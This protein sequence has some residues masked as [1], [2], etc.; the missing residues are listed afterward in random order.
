MSGVAFTRAST[1]GPILDFLEEG[2][3]CVEHVFHQADLPVQICSKPDALI[4]WRD[5]CKVIE[6]GSREIGDDALPARLAMAAGVAGLG[7]YGKQ[8]LTAPTLGAAIEQ[9]NCIN[10]SVLQSATEMTLS[11]TGE[12]AQWTYYVTDTCR[13]GRQKNE[14]L[15]LGYMLDLLRRFCGSE[16]IP[17]RI[18]ITPGPVSGRN[19][20]ETILKCEL[21]FDSIVAITFPAEYLE[22]PNPGQKD[23]ESRDGHPIPPADDFLC[24]VQELIRLGLLGGRPQRDWVARRLGISIRTLQRR[25]YELNTSYAVVLRT[26]IAEQATELMRYCDAPISEIAYDLGY[27][28]PSHFSRAFTQHFGQSPSDWRRAASTKQN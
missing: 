7:D 4:P 24:C 1:L 19:S 26:I 6:L 11:I 8:F 28:D 18:S 17:N 20:I 12:T 27:S 13:I 22:T 23:G 14:I 10:N 16:W 21:S 2:G 25:L 5:Q 15:T 3:G 9:G